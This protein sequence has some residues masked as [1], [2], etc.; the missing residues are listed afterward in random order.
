[1]GTVG[2][3]RWVRYGGYG[4]RVPVPTVPYPP[5][6]PYHRTH[7]TVP[8][9]PTVPYPAY[10]PYRTHRTKRPHQRTKTPYPPYRTHRKCHMYL[11]VLNH[12]KT[13]SFLLK[14]DNSCSIE[15]V[16]T[17]SLRRYTTIHTKSQ[18]KES[19]DG[20]GNA[21]WMESGSNIVRLPCIWQTPHVAEP[22]PL[23]FRQYAHIFHEWNAWARIGILVDC[24]SNQ[25]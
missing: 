2:T 9:V 14:F 13:F 20:S 4:G 24:H 6:P 23:S 16:N 15:I 7:C 10:P 11:P 12:Q 22:F 3:V 8:T 19:H 21:S 25:N 5:Y 17:A 1:M 18:N